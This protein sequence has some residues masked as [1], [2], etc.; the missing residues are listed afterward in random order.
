MDKKNLLIMT[1][2]IFVA[3]VLMLIFPAN[4]ITMEEAIIKTNKGDIKVA[5]YYD[6]T[7]ITVEN[8][9]KLAQEG[10]YDDIKFHRVI[11]NFMI[12]T[13]DPQAKGE[14]GKD[15]V[16]VPNGSA[17]PIAGTGGPGYTF[18][19]E[20]HPNLRHNITGTLSMAN[21]GPNTNGSQ[22]FITH[23][24]TPWLDDKHTVFG[25]VLE[26]QD[27]VNSIV[28]GDYIKKIVIK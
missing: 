10:F 26:G 27:V 24:P 6:K 14:E 17:L 25:R 16:Y 19:D 5:L 2:V 7:P 11:E 9:V 23:V 21:S 28:Q 22:F 13:G 12:Q 18:Q 8:F 1:G 3:L 4:K 20:F 15:F